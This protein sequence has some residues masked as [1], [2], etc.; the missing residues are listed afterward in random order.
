MDG[1]LGGGGHAEALLMRT[2]P[3]GRLLG[4]DRDPLALARAAERLAAYGDRLVLAEGNIADLD[5]VADANAW[6]PCNGILF[7]LGISSDQL[8]D[9]ARG[10]SFQSDGPL[11]MRLGPDA[12]MTAADWVND[13]AEADLADVPARAQH[14]GRA[15]R[16]VPPMLNITFRKLA[17]CRAEDLGSGQVATRN[18]EGHRVLTLVAKTVCTSGLIAAGTGVESGGERLIEQPAH[19]QKIQ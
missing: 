12:D 10:L 4:V 8:D 18:R 5:A 17:R 6:P 1:T 11:D 15:G 14:P 9:P 3:D 16:G 2:A 7:D 13:A 19:S